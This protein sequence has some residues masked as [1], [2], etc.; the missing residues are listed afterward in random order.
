MP[1]AKFQGTDGVR[2]LAV[3]GDHPQALGVDARAAFVEHGVL[4]PRFIEHYVF[5]AG[6]RL[7]ERASERLIS[8]VAVVLAW[9]PRDESGGI[10]PPRA[11]ALFC[12]RG[13]HVLSLGVMPTPVAAAYLAGVGGAGAVMLTASH[14][15]ADQNGVKILLS[16]DSMKPLPEEDEAISA[17]VWASDW[18]SVAQTPARGQCVESAAEARAFYVDYVTKLPNCWLRAGDLARVGFRHRPGGRGVE[19]VGRPCSGGNV[20]FERAGG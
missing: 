14:N 11:W 17:R 7:L 8:P 5:E 19:R 16:P 1:N 2:G 18:A 13:A 10:P 4:T 15:P 9:D 12:A 3:D 20:T 6:C